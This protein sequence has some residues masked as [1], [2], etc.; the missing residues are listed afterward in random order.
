MYQ[1][2][3][4]SYRIGD[5][6]K[7]KSQVPDG[8]FLAIGANVEAA[9][10][11]DGKGQLKFTA[12]LP[13]FGVPHSWYYT[14]AENSV[15]RL[16]KDLVSCGILNEDT[17]VSLP[18]DGPT[19]PAAWLAPL[20]NAFNQQA[21]MI[22]IETKGDY[23]NTYLR[24]RGDA[25]GAGGFAPPTAAATAPPTPQPATVF[26]APA[27]PA[28]PPLPPGW[29]MTP[30]GP[31]PTSNAVPPTDGAGV[32]GGGTPGAGGMTFMRPHTGPGHTPWP[33][34]SQPV[35]PPPGAAPS[36]AAPTAFG[37]VTELFRG[38]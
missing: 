18:I 26:A 27:A 34:T 5:F 31:Q 25:G 7:P 17:Q 33:P 11:K 14:M 10:T 38:Q 6:L 12:F 15:W 2:P 16:F 9:Q 8:D 37:N 22:H 23:T 20:Q 19:A 36:A 3:S 13:Q 21:W 24:A 29:V 4:Q 1:Q 32:A 28:T 35:G 30:Q